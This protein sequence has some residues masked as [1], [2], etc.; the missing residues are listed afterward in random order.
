MAP[1]GIW[2]SPA[3]GSSERASVQS[4]RELVGNVARSA[5][6][7][8]LR[9]PVYGACEDSRCQRPEFLNVAC[10]IENIKLINLNVDRCGGSALVR[11]RSFRTVFGQPVPEPQPDERTRNSRYPM[12]MLDPTQIH[13]E[14]TCAQE[15]RRRN[16]YGFVGCA[17]DGQ[18]EGDHPASKRSERAERSINHHKMTHALLDDS[19][20]IRCESS[21]ALAGHGVPTPRPPANQAASSVSG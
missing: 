1:R 11:V 16:V 8:S 13:A 12:Y 9:H 15:T 18:R 4:E 3:G 17:C 5:D 14:G 10:G 19:L 20:G 21:N 6:P 7:S 2:C